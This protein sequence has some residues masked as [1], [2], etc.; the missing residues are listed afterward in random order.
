[1]TFIKICGLKD[2]QTARLCVELGVQATGFVFYEKSARNLSLGQAR[3]ITG[4]LP[5][6]ML[7]VAVMVNPDAEEAAAMAEKAGCNAIQLHGNESPETAQTLVKKGFKVIKAFYMEGQPLIES[8][9]KFPGVLPLVEAASAKMPGGNA[10]A[11]DWSSAKNF[12][13]KIPLIL[14][15]G[16]NP[17]NIARALEAARPWGV[18]VSSGVESVPGIKDHEKI[19]HFVEKVRRFD[20]E[21]P[22][23]EETQEAFP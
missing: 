2:L 23:H 17:E 9:E 3:A 5:E 16:L 8:A 14:A 19:R 10:L 12:S 6:N 22:N 18:D 7:R 21:N 20:A 4:T 1:M 15:G 13:K 11:W